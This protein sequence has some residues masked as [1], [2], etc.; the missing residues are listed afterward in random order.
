[1]TRSAALFSLPRY[2]PCHYPQVQITRP[3]LPPPVLRGRVGRGFFE[4]TSSI[5]QLWVMT[6][7]TSGGG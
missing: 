7:G 2:V 4:R 1:M 5:T 6:S 3:F